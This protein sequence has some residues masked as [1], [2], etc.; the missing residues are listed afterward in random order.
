MQVNQQLL[1]K[2]IVVTRPL[3][4]AQNIC[5]LL[6][7]YQATVIHFPVLKI[8][9]IKETKTVKQKLQKLDDYEMII[10][11]SANAVR[12]AMQLAQEFKTV[13]DNKNLIVIGPA[14]KKALK[15]HGL[16]TNTSPPKNYT[17]ETLLEEES[18]QNLNGKRILIIRGHG[19]RETLRQKLELRGAKVEYAEVYQR[20]LPK[21]RSSIDLSQLS[22]RNTVILIYSVESAQN[23]WSLCSINEQQWLKNIT[24]VAGGNRIAKSLATVGF[25]KNPIIAENPNDEA[26]L[27]ALFGWANHTNE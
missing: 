19:G 1:G 5:E 3:A 20:M 4:Q 15:N 6:E 16:S 23:L 10:F 2:T 25:A 26:M 24:V 21:Q 12:Y 7:R 17:S 27:N 9:P 11:I 18:L 22:S 14:T 13:F 8:A